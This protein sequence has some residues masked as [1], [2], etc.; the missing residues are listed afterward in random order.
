M[1]YANIMVDGTSCLTA[2]VGL[3]ITIATRRGSGLVLSSVPP[4]PWASL[5]HLTAVPQLSDTSWTTPA[6]FSAPAT[7]KT[8][9]VVSSPSPWSSRSALLG[10]VYL[11]DLSFCFLILDIKPLHHLCFLHQC[12]QTFALIITLWLQWRSPH[13]A[14][15]RRSASL[16]SRIPPLYQTIHI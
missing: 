6:D 13:Q 9:R 16:L 12:V 15:F 4:P 5:S 8:H 11:C 2:S 10:V 7:Q 3:F 1:S 14:R